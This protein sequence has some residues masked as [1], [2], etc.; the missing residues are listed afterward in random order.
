MFL[1]KCIQNA[2]GGFK[3]IQLTRV[4]VKIKLEITSTLKLE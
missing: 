2:G 1:D 3:I 4:D